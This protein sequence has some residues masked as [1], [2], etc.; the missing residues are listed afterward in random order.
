M[1][2]TLYR[3]ALIPA[4]LLA[5]AACNTFEGLGQDVQ[6]GGQAIEDTAEDVQD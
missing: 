3:I 6:S 5:L 4:F 2:S 1:S